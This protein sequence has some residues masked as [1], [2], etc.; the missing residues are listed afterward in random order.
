MIEDITERRLAA[1]KL[2]EQAA[3]LDL[4][5]DAIIVRD[6]EGRIIF[7]NRGAR[8]TY[9]WSAEEA[10]G[11]VAHDL[12][13][14]RFP[15]PLQEIEAAVLAQERWDGEL[16][17]T[18]RDGRTITEASRWSLRRDEHG[19]P[20]ALLE[21]N[22]DISF[23]KRA[24]EE[25]RTL[26]ER[27]RMATSTASIGVWDWDLRSNM[28]V[29]D[30][31][32]FKIFGIAKAVP[33]AYE[34]FSQLVHPADAC[35]ASKLHWRGPSRGRH[36][37]PWNSGSSGR[38]VRCGMFPRSKELC[39]MSLGTWSAWWEPQWT[40]RNASKWRRRLRPTKSN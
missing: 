25:L 32:M 40:S 35:Q 23:K 18:T 5:H 36:R 14:T 11:R 31:A 4:A 39:W 13:Q 22:R 21:I 2:A 6:L 9:G 28:T 29:W 15:I 24:E 38:T 26:S 7:W 12:L 34:S 10:M 19:V 20:A 30:D 16:E 3:L 17:H 37:I 27:L 8:D 33:M 1:H